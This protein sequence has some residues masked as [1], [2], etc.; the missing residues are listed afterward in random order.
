M[1]FRMSIGIIV[2]SWGRQCGLGLAGVA[3]GSDEA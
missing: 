1:V 3:G 2:L